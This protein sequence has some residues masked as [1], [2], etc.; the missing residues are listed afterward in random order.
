[1][2]RQ[3]DGDWNGT[4]WQGDI[5][6]TGGTGGTLHATLSC[7]GSHMDGQLHRLRHVRRDGDRHLFA[8]RPVGH[9]VSHDLLRRREH[10]RAVLRVSYRGAG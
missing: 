9:P 10:D 2:L 5:T 3:F 7:S 8:V 4:N 6:L 1:V